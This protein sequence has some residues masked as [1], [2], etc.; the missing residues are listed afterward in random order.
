MQIEMDVGSFVTDLILIAGPLSIT[1]CRMTQL[2]NIMS[3]GKFRAEVCQ[4][5]G[6]E[7]RGVCVWP[8]MVG[9]IAEGSQW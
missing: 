7:A 8:P 6:R 2:L 3:S 5:R 9:V 1:S 4:R